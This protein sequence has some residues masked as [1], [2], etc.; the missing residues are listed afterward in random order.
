MS[1]Q[2][3]SRKKKKNRP[4]HEEISVVG[5][6][7]IQL[8][9]G[10]LFGKKVALFLCGE[11]HHDAIDVTRSNGRFLPKEGWV[12]L[13]DQQ[14]PVDHVAWACRLIKESKK[15]LPVAKAQDWAKEVVE[16]DSSVEF[17][18]FVL[19]WI[20]VEDSG[21][22][23]SRGKSYVCELRPQE[24]LE[25][26]AFFD[27]N[28]DEQNDSDE[29]DIILN[30]DYWLHCDSNKEQRQQY[31]IEVRKWILGD[32]DCANNNDSVRPMKIFEWGDLDPEA[33]AIN[34]RRLAKSDVS[35]AEFD[36]MINKRKEDRKRQNI[37]T[38]DDW[39]SH[40][41]SKAGNA[42]IYLVAEATLPPWEV[43]VHRPPNTPEWRKELSALPQAVDCI[44]CVSEDSDCSTI[45]EHDVAS[46]G[47]GGYADYFYRRF[48]S[49]M[50]E[51]NKTMEEMRSTWFHC[52]DIRDLGCEGACHAKEVKEKW[53]EL[54]T[55]EEWQDATGTG[56]KDVSKA[57][58]LETT[59]NTLSFQS[60]KMLNT[61]Q[62]CYEE[63]VQNGELQSTEEE[64][65]SE[66]ESD[67]SDSC[68]EITFPS[69][70]GFLG[71]ST[72]ILYYSP[73]VRISYSPFLARVVRSLFNWEQ[74]FPKLFFGGTISDAM[75]YLDLPSRGDHA[76]VRS[77]ILKEWDAQSNTYIWK[78]RP[79]CYEH[80]SFPFFPYAFHLKAKGSNPP[81]T[82]SS[83][84]HNNLLVSDDN[85]QRSF[86]EKVTEW[87]LRRIRYVS[88]DPKLHDDLKTGGDWF[89][90]YL[91]AAHRE[92]YDDIDHTDVAELL[93]RNKM[94]S[95]SGSRAY[96]I[97]NIEV[98]SCEDAFAE[99][100]QRFD[101][102]S[103]ST[104]GPPH[105]IEARTETLA[106]IIIDIWMLNLVDYCTLLKIGNLV[107]QTHS[108]EVVV[109][110]YLGLAHTRTIA[111][112]LCNEAGFQKR[113]YYGKVS[114]EDD[115]SRKIQL[116]SRLWN[117]AELFNSNT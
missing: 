38:F 97:G 78:K 13:S 5:P 104:P 101:E 76:Y 77:P 57:N 6:D 23:G 117:P 24:D 25:R 113:G 16:N 103:G 29:E 86:A 92:I 69:F 2:R 70:E 8:L 55:L 31:P 37:W 46:D 106:K 82:W 17:G 96:A 80:I 33:F 74:F 40:I 100:V 109:V 11:S 32:D 95:Q 63:K 12:A 59:D 34:K 27:E 48:M 105:P 22:K 81:R 56:N 58:H 75:Q 52:V 71:Q 99:I 54:L 18:E 85:R 44:R 7:K 65:D 35:E 102:V 68:L 20:E 91:R 3:K 15:L 26:K 45:D 79:E 87:T 84:L 28:N 61:E 42:A 21:R 4:L 90:G 53:K 116:P 107:A 108:D 98:P 73:H 39:F 1:S 9:Q 30:P 47:V 67:G 112:F 94:P 10:D 19:V 83:Q 14:L 88:Q 64:S 115:E 41:R 51:E 66:S 89:G 111:D 114:W 62:R 110:C 50:I 36:I 60:M 93:T 43:E 49:E 72:D